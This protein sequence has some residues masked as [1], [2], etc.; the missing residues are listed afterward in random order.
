MADKFVFADEAGCFK[1]HKKKGASKYFMLCTISLDECSISSDLLAIKRRL[2]AA[3]DSKRNK[4]HATTDPLDVRDE[5]YGI[6]EAADFSIDCTILEKTKAQPQTRTDAPRFY[7]YAWFYHFKAVGP[8]VCKQ[9]QKTLITAASIDNKKMRGAFMNSVNNVA[10]Q[11][12]PR[13][14]WEVN[15]IESSQDPRLWAADYCAWAIQRKWE[16]GDD[17]YYR[18]VKNK[19]ATEFD[20]WRVGTKHYY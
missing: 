15:F 7:K 8:Q 6:L 9:G 14:Q 1:F 11:I 12:V 13:D 3:G 17:S 16:M 10:Q 5:V 2:V 18:R 19:I 20:L 4:L